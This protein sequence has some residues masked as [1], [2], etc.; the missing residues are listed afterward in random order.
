MSSY[1]DGQVL[2]DCV[3]NRTLIP[4]LTNIKVGGKSPSQYLSELTK[5]NP[6]IEAALASQMIPTELASGVYDDVYQVF[7]E[8]RA[9]AII[10]KA[11]SAILD[12]RGALIAGLSG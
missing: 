6:Q 10:E 11:K 9:R 4:K 7:L 3:V 5:K 2:V 12:E 1:L 8:D